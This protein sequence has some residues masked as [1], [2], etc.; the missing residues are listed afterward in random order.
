MKKINGNTLFLV[1]STIILVT[2]GAIYHKINMNKVS[3]ARPEAGLQAAAV[4]SQNS[5]DISNKIVDEIKNKDFELLQV[6]SPITFGKALEI[7]DYVSK[8]VKIRPAFLLAIVQEELTLEKS[9][10]CY[11]TNFKTGEGIR[12]T[13]SKILQN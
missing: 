6:S 4:T 2:S 10:L 12:L 5:N 8:I 9:D 3:I 1:A 13:D 7:A 11:V